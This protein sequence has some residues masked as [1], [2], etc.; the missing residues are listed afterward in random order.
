MLYVTIETLRI[1]AILLQPVHAGAMGKLL[2]LLGVDPPSARNFAALDSRRGRGRSTRR[3]GCGRAPRCRRPRRSFRAMSRPRPTRAMRLIDSHCHLDFPDFADELEAI[4]AR[5]QRGG[6]RAADHD[7]DPRRAWRAACRARRA[8]STMS[9]SRSARIRIRRPR[10][11]RSTPRRSTPSPRIPNAS[12]SARPGSTTTTITRRATSPRTCFARRSAS[13]ARSDLPLV[14][15]ARDADDDIAAILREEMGQG[16]FE[17]VLHCFTSSRALAETG[18]ELGLLRLVLRRA[19]LQEFA[20]AAGRSRATF[21]STACWSRPTRRFSRRCRIAASAT[22]PPSSSRR[23]ASLAEV[24]GVDDRGDR[25]GD[26][27]QHAAAVFENAAAGGQR[28]EPRAHD[29]GLRLVGRRAARRAGLG[30]LRSRNPRNRR[31]RCSVLVER[32]GRR[33]QDVRARRHLAGPARAIARR[34]RSIVSTAC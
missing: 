27:R 5:A 4:V 22:S 18:L 34:R 29:P 30:R 8:L 31:R 15:H 6:R 2:D 32:I 13:P 23:R 19:D 33:R 26:A 1:A 24:K 25:R 16:A 28:R 11:R 12:A 3:I 21:R 17:A 10:S 9:I 7:L 14:I 20:G